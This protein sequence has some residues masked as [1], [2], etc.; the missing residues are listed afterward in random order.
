[1]YTFV[2]MAV[3]SSGGETPTWDHRYYAYSCNFYSWGGDGC[4]WFPSH[5]AYPGNVWG[6]NP[7]DAWAAYARYCYSGNAGLP[8]TVNPAVFGGAVAPPLPPAGPMP[9]RAP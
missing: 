5:N 6:P 1:M 7:I 8:P 4:D 9:Y 3:L 2:L